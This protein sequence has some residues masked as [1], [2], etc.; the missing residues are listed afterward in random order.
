MGLEMKL[1]IMDSL[2]EVEIGTGSSSGRK[3]GDV[4]PG[5]CGFF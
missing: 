5:K 3:R 2:R 1:R 4:H